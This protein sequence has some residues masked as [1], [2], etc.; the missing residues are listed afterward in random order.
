MLLTIGARKL[1]LRRRI[2]RNAVSSSSTPST[3]APMSPP[4][5]AT[6]GPTPSQMTVLHAG[7]G[8]DHEHLAVG[9]VQEPQHAEDQGIADRDQGIGAAQHHA[10][11][12]LLQ[13]HEGDSRL[14][15]PPA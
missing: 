7:E 9:E 13:K 15:G 4:I 2:G 3:A 10:V 14:R 1:P 5:S 8:A 6:N 12:E 11:G